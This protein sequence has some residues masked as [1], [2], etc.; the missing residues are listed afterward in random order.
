MTR[1][2]TW[3][4]VRWQHAARSKV[5]HCHGKTIADD[6]REGCRIGIHDGPWRECVHV[7]CSEVEEPVGVVRKEG[8]T[9]EIG[10]CS[11]ELGDEFWVLS[12]SQLEGQV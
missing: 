8:Q 11:F 7:L 5:E 4:V 1:R 2:L 3:V 10:S 6:C 12:G 9:I